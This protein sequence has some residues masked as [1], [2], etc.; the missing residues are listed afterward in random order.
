VQPKD[1]PVNL[2]TFARGIE[3]K[4]VAKVIAYMPKD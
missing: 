2:R 4:V 1:K 3:A